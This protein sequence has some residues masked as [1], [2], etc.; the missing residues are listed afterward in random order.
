MKRKIISCTMAIMLALTTFIPKATFA[1]SNLLYLERNKQTITSG[2]TYEESHR[3]YKSGW[4]DVYVLTVDVKNPN[5]K[6]EVLE[7]TTEYGLKKNTE[8]LVKENGAIAGINGDF[9][10][11]GNPKS[12][13]GQVIEESA[14]EAQNYY[15]HSENKYAGVFLDTFGN[16]FVDYM[17]SNIRLYNSKVNLDL[18]AKNKITDFKKPVIFDKTA[19]ATTSDLDKRNAN[20][21]KIVVEN[22]VIKQK[23]G[24][25]QVATVPENGYIVVMDKNTATT[26]LVN[27]V[28]GEAITFTE[29]YSFSFRPEKNV[30]EVVMGMSAGGEILRN[31]KVISQG[32]SISPSTRQPRTAIGV[33][34]DKS[35]LIMMVVDGRGTSVGATHSEMAELLLEYGAYDAIHFDGGGSST[36]VVREE[37]DTEVSLVNN[38]SEQTQRLVP[39]GLGIKTTNQ[40]GELKTLKIEPTLNEGQA[41][42]AGGTYSFTVYGFDENLNHVEIDLSQV[43]V[44]FATEDEGIVTGSAF[45]PNKSGEL[46]LKA[47]YTNGATGEIKINVKEEIIGIKPNASKTALKISE[48]A[49]LS[50]TG[51]NGDGYEM[52]IDPNQIVWTV[53]NEAVGTITGNVFTAKTDGVA[54]LTGTYGS[55]TASITIAVGESPV[56]IE[57]FESPKEMFMTY[58][59]ENAGVSGGAAIAN[60]AFNDGGNSLLLSYSFKENSTSSQASYVCFE[61]SPILFTGEPSYIEMMV[62]GDASGNMLKAVIKDKNNKQ[63]IV[64][65]IENM[66][67]NEW[68]LARF[69]VPAEA[70]YP[71]RLDKLYV[72]TYATTAKEQGTVYIDNISGVVKRTD[73]GRLIGGYIDPISASLKGTSPLANEE[74]INVFGQTATKPHANSKQVLQ[75]AIN[76]MKLNATSMIFAGDSNLEGIATDVPTIQ[77]QNKYST[78]ETKNLSVINLATK[79]GNMR[80][81]SPDQW[82]WLQSYLS[83]LS[84]NNVVINMDKNIWD[85]SNHLTGDREN[86]LFHK[87]LKKCFEETGKNILVVSAVG[88]KSEVYVKDGIRYIT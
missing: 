71:V 34:Q 65:I 62:K 16:I 46:T 15:N 23:L 4:K 7:S 33:S 45:K 52:Y 13:M 36:M 87:I 69:P 39:N 68:V 21:F 79:S 40:T 5:V 29:S 73:G 19:I 55:Y 10:G 17:K 22:G 31:G 48:T 70:T 57:S 60:A 84:K 63:Y 72:G 35:K 44:S 24:A 32:M 37:G 81:E 85:S 26:N 51:V 42:V 80:T 8:N 78:S 30:K 1:N 50:A 9:F 18:G 11:S 64:P 6:L 75:D 47:T 53:D 25:G 49:T 43:N 41:I 58:Y 27:F 20:L 88:D 3:L 83:S 54:T 74:E 2:V 82:R 12:A 76:V 56:L 59:P 38:V 67:S 86:E 66:N 77:W 14:I 61:K 28:I